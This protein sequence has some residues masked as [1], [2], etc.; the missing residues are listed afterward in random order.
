MNNDLTLYPKRN[1]P[2]N[3]VYRSD[4]S[5]DRLTTAALLNVI[6]NGMKV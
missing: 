4:V 5:R 6:T 3:S 2:N 1:S